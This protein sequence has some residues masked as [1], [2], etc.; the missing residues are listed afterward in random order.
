MILYV[1]HAGIEVTNVYNSLIKHNLEP[2]EKFMDTYVDPFQ[3][4]ETDKCRLLRVWVREPLL[5]SGVSGCLL[6]QT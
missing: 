3:F 4:F 1:Q 6:M 5:V 2:L